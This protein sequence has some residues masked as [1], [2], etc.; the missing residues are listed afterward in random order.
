MRIFTIQAEKWRDNGGHDY[1]G[2][3][4]VDARTFVISIKLQISAILSARA[5][6]NHQPTN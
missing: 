2:V 5:I 4:F 6:E 3:L 1:G